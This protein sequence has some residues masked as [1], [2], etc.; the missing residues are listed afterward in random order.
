MQRKD[1]DAIVV[2]T[3]HHLHLKEVMMALESG[4]HVL[5]EKP[6][7]T[8]LEDADR[9]LAAAAKHRRVLG[10]AHNLRFRAQCAQGAR[11]GRGQRHRQSAEHAFFDDPATGQC[12]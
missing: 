6:M 3:P 7:A 2:T 1:I 10:V 5:V 9:M 8:T 12:R 4:K 11:I